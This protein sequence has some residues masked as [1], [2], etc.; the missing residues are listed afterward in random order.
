M[1]SNTNVS[2][3]TLTIF[4]TLS[5]LTSKFIGNSGVETTGSENA[6]VIDAILAI[7]LWLEHDDKFVAGP[8]EDDD[9]LQLLQTL[10]LISANCQNSTLR[11][12][13]HVLTS[14]ILHA[15]PTDRVRLTFISDTLE[16]CPFEPLRASA[17]GFL[18]EELILAHERKRSNIFSSPAALSAVQ[19]YLFPY[20]SVMSGETETELWEDF[21]RTYPFHMA[22]LNFLFF[23]DSGPYVKVVP[24]GSLSVVEEIYLAPLRAARERL[25]KA[26]REEGGFWKEL[27]E[28]EAREGLSEV[29]LLGERLDVCLEEGRE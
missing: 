3:P 29:R 16:H 25:E 22:A 17:V 19:P 8:L 21:K 2:M 15:H 5:Q 27:G 13:A 1:F 14:N 26:L 24:E 7:G 6:S 18:K 23:L 9:F 12:N 20:E 4:P 28:E 10:S 11:Y